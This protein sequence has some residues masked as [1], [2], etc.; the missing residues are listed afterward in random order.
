MSKGY[1]N[2]ALKLLTSN[3]S[4]G[5]LPLSNKTL[6]YETFSGN[7][8]AG[9]AGADSD[10]LIRGGGDLN[11]NLKNEQKQPLKKAFYK[12]RYSSK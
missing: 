12:N 6:D 7:P 8:F 5:I 9:S 3:F 2:G 1:V 10:L 11:W 4:N